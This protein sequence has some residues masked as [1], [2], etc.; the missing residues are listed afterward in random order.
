M[1][2]QAGRLYPYRHFLDQ[3]WES[4]PSPPVKLEQPAQGEQEEQLQPTGNPDPLRLDTALWPKTEEKGEGEVEMKC[5][6]CGSDFR[7]VE[8]L[9]CHLNL[10]LDSLASLPG[11]Q[12]QP[13]R[14]A[15]TGCGY[16]PKP[17]RTAAT[18]H[19]STLKVVEEHIRAKHLKLPAWQCLYCDKTFN[20]KA[21]LDYHHR[22]HNDPTKEYCNI[23]RHFKSS[24]KFAH[25]DK[26]KCARLANAERKFK[27]EDCGKRFKGAAN[28]A[29][30][31]T[32]HSE[33]RF[34]CDFC[35]RAFTQKGNRKTHILKKHS[36]QL[37]ESVS[38][39]Q[40]DDDGAPLPETTLVE[41][42]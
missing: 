10:H 12:L 31:R 18:S 23:C 24:D 8:L 39:L 4:E 15:V 40:C 36:E 34:I 25:H 9:V 32:I 29:L 28:L 17:V 38:F 21:S 13:L 27:C 2:G 30:H 7:E 6:F 33:L 16:K 26:V 42:I 19:Y 1:A 20:S 5:Q 41:N 3:D 14:C 11:T 35:G 22:M 37:A